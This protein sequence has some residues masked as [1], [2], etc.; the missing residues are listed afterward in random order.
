MQL[1]EVLGR[2]ESLLKIRM[3]KDQGDGA[4]SAL[5]LSYAGMTKG[6]TALA[7]TMILCK[8]LSFSA[9]QLYTVYL[10]AILALFTVNS[11]SKAIT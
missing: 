9:T 6:F 1:E 5:K 4:A 3:L 7:S 10:K 2:N 11:C 8:P